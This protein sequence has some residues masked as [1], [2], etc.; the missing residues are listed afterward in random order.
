[1]ITGC[2][3]TK[4]VERTKENKG[5]ECKIDHTKSALHEGDK[6]WNRI[7]KE[8]DLNGDGIIDFEEFNLGIHK[9]MSET[10]KGAT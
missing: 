5:K 1:V 3:E 7:L 8:I 4:H 6:K 9:F 10:Y 2:S